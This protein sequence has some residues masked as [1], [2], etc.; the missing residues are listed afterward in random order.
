MFTDKVGY[1][2]RRPH[3]QG[4][5]TGTARPPRG[6]I[7]EIWH[8]S[9]G[10][11]HIG[12]IPHPA[13]VGG[14]ILL[15]AVD[16]TLFINNQPRNPQDTTVL[17]VEAHAARVLKEGSAD[18]PDSLLQLTQFAIRAMH[19]YTSGD[20]HAIPLPRPGI[21]TNYDPTQSTE[22]ANAR[23][24]AEELFLPPRELPVLSPQE[25]D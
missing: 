21:I 4:L 10:T 19:A 3:P 5:H 11:I 24:I 18:T 7:S 17:A 14:S 6:L 25:V 13:V 2:G 23:I 12:R 22:G 1:S 8:R 20:I 9:D 15:S 16:T